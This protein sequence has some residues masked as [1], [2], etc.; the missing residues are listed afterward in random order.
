MMLPPRIML[1]YQSGP[2]A[3][4]AMAGQLV[5]VW[6]QSGAG[7]STLLSQIWGSRGIPDGQLVVRIQGRD[8]DLRTLSPA[9]LAWVRPKLMAYLPQSPHVPPG[10]RIGDWFATSDARLDEELAALDLLPEL[11]ARRASELSGGELR[12]FCLLRVLFSDAPIL[13]LDE[14]C[15]GLDLDRQALIQKLMCRAVDEGRLVVASGHAPAPD[16]DQSIRLPI[17]TS[18]ASRAH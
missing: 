18:P 7:K 5:Y 8:L 3:L 10:V 15:S 6:G 11:L 4:R 9:H 13:L 14:P 12:R 16:A 1:C 2:I 17:S